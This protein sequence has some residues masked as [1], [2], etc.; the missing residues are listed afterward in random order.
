MQGREIRDFIALFPCFENAFL[1]VFSINTMP[2]TLIKRHFF[3][4]NTDLNFESGSHWICVIRNDNND[5]ELFDSLGCDSK[6]LELFL[7]YCKIKNRKNLIYNVT[8]VQDFLS[9]TCGKFVLYF[10]I[11]R[12]F[13]LDCSFNKVINDIFEFEAS[14]NEQKVVDFI[15]AF[16][17]G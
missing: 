13:N 6:K 7:N 4:T 8:P 5:I 14:K 15:K 17:N 9:D 1:G 2:K 11:K 10:A 16:Q 12:L 3:I